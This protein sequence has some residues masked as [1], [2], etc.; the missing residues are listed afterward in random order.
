MIPH[1]VHQ[2]WLGGK[3]LPPILGAFVDAVRWGAMVRLWQC[4]LWTERELTVEFGGEWSQLYSQC[5]HVSQASDVARYL[6]L[7]KH[8]GLYLDTDVELFRLPE[9]VDLAG[10]PAWIAGTIDPPGTHG[11]TNGCCLASEPGGAYV[12]RMLNKIQSGQVDLGRHMAAGPFLCGDSLGPDVGI[13][14]KHVWHGKRGDP[15]V[16]GHHY[17]W[18]PRLKSFLRAHGMPPTT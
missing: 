9:G 6:I 5:C 17:G 14:Q 4:Q 10:K 1:V 3:P 16:C 18:G 13:W 2:V 15:G 7:R 8:G 12:T 11:G